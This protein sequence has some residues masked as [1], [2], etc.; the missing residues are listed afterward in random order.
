MSLTI[1]VRLPAAAAL[2]ANVHSY[3]FVRAWLA[4]G[5]PSLPIDAAAPGAGL[6][7]NLRGPTYYH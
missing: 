6:H 4:S 7:E 1:N 3:A 5:R 2:S